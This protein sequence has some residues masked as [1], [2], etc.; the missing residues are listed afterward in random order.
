ME[1]FDVVL[2]KISRNYY[3]GKISDEEMEKQ[4]RAA[5]DSDIVRPREERVNSLLKR[6]EK[7][8]A[9]LGKAIKDATQRLVIAQVKADMRMTQGITT[10]RN[11]KA[12]VR[13]K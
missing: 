13:G 2:K 1:E 12:Q 3:A 11:W 9:G 5:I 7:G 6:K 4:L 8:E 10:L